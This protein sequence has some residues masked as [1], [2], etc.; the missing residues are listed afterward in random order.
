MGEEERGTM[1]RPIGDSV[2]ATLGDYL[3]RWLMSYGGAFD[4][5]FETSSVLHL[6]IVNAALDSREGVLTWL[7]GRSGSPKLISA[8]PAIQ[9]QI[10]MRLVHNGNGSG[11]APAVAVPAVEN[12]ER[13]PELW[14]TA[15]EAAMPEPANVEAAADAIGPD[16]IS[17]ESVARTYESTVPT[18]ADAAAEHLAPTAPSQEMV[19]EVP[20][21]PEPESPPSVAARV[22]TLPDAASLEIVA[23]SPEIEAQPPPTLPEGAAWPPPLPALADYAPL[24]EPVADYERRRDKRA[25]AALSPDLATRRVWTFIRAAQTNRGAIAHRW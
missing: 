2:P 7:E 17:P 1:A 3:V 23:P 19:V 11:V 13:S 18:V 24:P 21:L 6:R 9:R 15:L 14:T 20:S 12:L 16:A 10:E 8:S 4:W 5:V 22:E 25:R